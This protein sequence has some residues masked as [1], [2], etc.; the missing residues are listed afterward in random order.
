[1]I[2][3]EFNE[4][5]LNDILIR[6]SEET[7]LKAQRRSISRVASRV[8]TTISREIRKEYNLKARDIK[9][10][11]KTLKRSDGLVVEVD[12]KNYKLIQFNAVRTVRESTIPK[13]KIKKNQTATALPMMFY[14]VMQSGHMGIYM[15]GRAMEKKGINYGSRTYKRVKLSTNQREVEELAINEMVAMDTADMVDKLEIEDKVLEV[16]KDNFQSEVMRLLARNVIG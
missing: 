14:A 3:I 8:V 10:H 13:V 7:I 9:K 4:R 15:R 11:I 6:Y 2:R 1:M 16:F 5:E 12:E